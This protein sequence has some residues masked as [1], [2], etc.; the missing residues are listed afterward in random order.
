MRPR[1]PNLSSFIHPPHASNVFVPDPVADPFWPPG[2]VQPVE[3]VHPT[4][5]TG[6]PKITLFSVFDDM[7]DELLQILI[8]AAASAQWRQ[9]KMR[10]GGGDEADENAMIDGGDEEE[11]LGGGDE[12]NEDAVIDGGDEADEDDLLILFCF[13]V[14]LGRGDE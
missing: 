10:S 3:P 4:G 7:F 2:L 1:N 5:P 13:T 9:E 11:V 12:A 8:S 14:L 6:Q